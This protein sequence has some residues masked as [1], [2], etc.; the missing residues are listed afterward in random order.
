MKI[1][2]RTISTIF[3]ILGM[4]F[5]TI[6]VSLD[7]PIFSWASIVCILISL[8]TGGRWLRQRKK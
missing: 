8:V 6:G 5:L 2:R 7:N 4:A 3:L 1:D